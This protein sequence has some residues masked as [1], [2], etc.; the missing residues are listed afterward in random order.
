MVGS[1]VESVGWAVVWEEVVGGG[2][3]EGGGVWGKEKRRLGQSVH[4][5]INKFISSEEGHNG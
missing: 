3:S 4:A 2:L 5:A 1:E